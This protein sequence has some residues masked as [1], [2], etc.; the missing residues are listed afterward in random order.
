M[1][2]LRDSPSQKAKQ[3]AER[4]F[5][6]RL[7]KVVYSKYIKEVKDE[8]KRNRI[9]RFTKSD[10]SK[11]EQEIA[12]ALD[13]NLVQAVDPDFVIVDIQSFS[14][15]TFR[16]P[17]VKVFEGDIMVLMKDGTRRN[18]VNYPNTI[19]GTVKEPEQ[20]M[21]YVYMSLDKKSREERQTFISSVEGE[22]SSVLENI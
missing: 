3:Y 4:L 2:A 7:L 8:L 15:P 19:L 17:G 14:N 22:I 18:A 1:R 10:L 16:P 21:L 9:A 12:K 13:K 20:E 11:A 5:E 6:R